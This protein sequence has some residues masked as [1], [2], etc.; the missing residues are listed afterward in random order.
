MLG[1]TLDGVSTRSR[2]SPSDWRKAA[3]LLLPSLILLGAFTYWPV[4]QVVLRSLDQSRFRQVRQLGFGNYSRMLADPHFARAVTNNALYAGFTVGPSVLL[5][6]GFALALRQGTRLD[7]ALRT[8]VVL[9]ML[10]PLVAAA[11]LFSFILL[12]GEGL[13]DHYLAVLASARPIGWVT[14]RWRWAPS[15]GSPCG[16]IPDTTCCSFSPGWR[17]CRPN[18]WM[19]RGLTGLMPGS[20]CGIS[21]CRCSV[22]PSGSSC[23]SRC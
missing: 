16:R 10:I 11:G 7:A 4:V 9:P 1:A 12:P 2:R 3:L 23:R 14:R 18:W 6:L 8:L 5:A 21:R 13:L 19:R 17:R 15:S 22:P 20:G